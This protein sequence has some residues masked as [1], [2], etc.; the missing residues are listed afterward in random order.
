MN[1]GFTACGYL[2]IGRVENNAKIY[3]TKSARPH[4][5][6]FYPN[7]TKT[8]QNKAEQTMEMVVLNRKG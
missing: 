8:K 6:T 4:T 5:Q 2:R 3:M 1:N 7:S